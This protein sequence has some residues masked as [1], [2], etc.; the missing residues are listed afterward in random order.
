M[1]PTF[2]TLADSSA[3]KFQ[4]AFAIVRATLL[5]PS[6]HEI[7]ISLPSKKKKKKQL[8]A[9]SAASSI[10]DDD[11]SPFRFAIPLPDLDYPFQ[12]P[13]HRHFPKAGTQTRIS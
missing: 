12:A 5:L 9:S 10:R 7:Q 8:S 6:W 4:R 2:P 3:L 1:K 11:A 13:S